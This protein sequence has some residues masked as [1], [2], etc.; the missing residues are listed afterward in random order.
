[1]YK[2]GLIE[3]R[4]TH[5]IHS[6]K[7]MINEKNIKSI[8]EKKNLFNKFCWENWISTNKNTKQCPNYLNPKCEAI[9]MLE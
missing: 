5:I 7:P 2:C 3:H 9:K 8:P 6:L 1:M 4:S